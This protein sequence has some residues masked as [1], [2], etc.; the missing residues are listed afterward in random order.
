MLAHAWATLPLNAG[1]CNT[2]PWHKMRLTLEHA[3]CHPPEI[4]NSTSQ[5][6]IGINNLQ[7]DMC[8]SAHDFGA[9]QDPPQVR[10]LFVCRLPTYVVGPSLIGFVGFLQKEGFLC[11]Y[12]DFMSLVPFFSQNISA[13]TSRPF[14]GGGGTDHG[15]NHSLLLGELV[16]G[17]RSESDIE[18]LQDVELAD[19]GRGGAQS[20]RFRMMCWNGVEGCLVCSC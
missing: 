11:S 20:L 16:P 6:C 4:T 17:N 2:T 9:V 1:V 13:K 5:N 14:S 3:G 18:T 19:V 7:E 15:P 12:Q 8:A 10:F